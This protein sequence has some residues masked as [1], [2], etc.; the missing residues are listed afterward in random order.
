MQVGQPCICQR[1]HKGDLHTI[2]ASNQQTARNESKHI[3]PTV[4]VR[5]F[6]WK[7][8]RLFPCC[9]NCSCPISPRR[10]SLLF[11]RKKFHTVEKESSGYFASQTRHSKPDARACLFMFPTLLWISSE[12]VKRITI[13]SIRT[14]Q[15]NNKSLLKQCRNW[16]IQTNS[17]T[18]PITKHKIF[19]SAISLPN[20]NLPTAKTVFCWTSCPQWCDLTRTVS[21]QI[22]VHQ[23]AIYFS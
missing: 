16:A 3:E 15:A 20:F 8:T 11:R 19:C 2:R 5:D 10:T 23:S 22:P 18:E 1:L 13:Q 7:S 17:R 14:A 4:R 12:Y 9:I 6:T 21:L